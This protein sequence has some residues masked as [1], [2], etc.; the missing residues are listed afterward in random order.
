MGQWLRFWWTVKTGQDLT[1][2]WMA[3]GKMIDLVEIA[4]RSPIMLATPAKY[5][6][7]RL[8]GRWGNAHGG[9][10]QMPA[11]GGLASSPWGADWKSGEIVFG[12]DVLTPDHNCRIE[13]TIRV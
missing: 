1:D 10:I 5:P 6:E 9:L 8:N 12:G 11:T 3:H 2:V 13:I 7:V 4:E